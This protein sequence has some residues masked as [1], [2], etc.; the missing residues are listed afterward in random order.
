M[1]ARCSPIFHLLDYSSIVRG[2]FYSA[3]DPAS[4][5]FQDVP[6]RIAVVVLPVLIPEGHG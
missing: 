6:A 4:M 1:D 5:L 3:I 2:P